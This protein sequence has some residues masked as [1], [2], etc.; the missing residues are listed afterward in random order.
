MPF[1]SIRRVLYIEDDIGL[2]RLLQR[3]LAVKNI[4]FDLATTGAEGLEKLRQGNYDIVLLDNFLPDTTGIDMLDEICPLQDQPPIILLTASGDERLAVLAL[5]KGAADYAVKDVDQFYIELLPAIMHAAYARYRLMIENKQQRFDLENAWQKA[6]AANHAKSEFLATM[7]HEIRTPL[8]VI[9]GISTLLGTTSLNERQKELIS[10]LGTNAKVLLGLVND[11]LDLSRIESGQ[12]DLEIAHFDIQELLDNMHAMF[13]MDASRKGLDLQVINNTG[14]IR[15][16]GDMLRVQQIIT[17]LVSNAIKFTENGYVRLKADTVKYKDHTDHALC[18]TI[19]DS[20]IGIAEDHL[21]N[22][23]NKFVQADQSI[24]RRFGGSG[25]GLA[26]T[27]SFVGIMQGEISVQSKKGEGSE[28]T[29]ILPLPL[30]S[31]KREQVIEPVIEKHE[32]IEHHTQKHVLLVEDYPANVMIAT[33]MLENMGFK[34]DV[35]S[36][37]QEAIDKVVQAVIPYYAIFMDIQM[38]GMDGFEA[39]RQIRELE[40][41][42]GYSHYIIGATAHALSGDKERCLNAGMNDYISKPI[43]W[44]AVSDILKKIAV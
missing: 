38:H 40:K 13:H 28:F 34:V 41:S 8:N 43:D 20:G 27:Q 21:D 17:N 5:E 14:D 18:I 32:E 29:V 37:G 30:R 7:S 4:E 42:K 10:V 19:S 11:I 35:V 25:L 3:R 26:L 2:A 31:D 44:D 16:D 36:S 12:M 24:T 23:F 1:S 33:M 39:T 22:I 9:L 6:E 15:W